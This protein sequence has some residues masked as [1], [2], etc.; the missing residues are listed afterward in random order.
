MPLHRLTSYVL[1]TTIFTAWVSP[2]YPSSLLLGLIDG[3]DRFCCCE[4]NAV[5]LQL[6]S[7]TEGN[8]FTTTF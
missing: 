5:A 6:S 2:P 1:V 4:P 8:G 7:S 3:L